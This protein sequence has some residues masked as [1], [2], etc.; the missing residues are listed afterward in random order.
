MALTSAKHKKWWFALAGYVI[1]SFMP[2]GAFLGGV[3]SKTGL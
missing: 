2:I 1:G 3:K